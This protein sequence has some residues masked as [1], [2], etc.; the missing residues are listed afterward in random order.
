M[1][2][3]NRPPIPDANFKGHNNND[4]SVLEDEMQNKQDETIRGL[5]QSV[6]EIKAVSENIRGHLIDEEGLRRDIDTGFEKT[7]KAMG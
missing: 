5:S 4:Q 7:Q 2:R 1:R 6:S 3:T